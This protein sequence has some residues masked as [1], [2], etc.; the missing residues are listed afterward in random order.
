M[1]LDTGLIRIESQPQLIIRLFHRMQAVTA[2]TCHCAMGETFTFDQALIFPTSD[3]NCAIIPKHVVVNQ[4]RVSVFMEDHL[5]IFDEVIARLVIQ[6]I[7]KIRVR[8]IGFEEAVTL[9]ANLGLLMFIESKRVN[10]R[11]I[12]F[13]GKL[14]IGVGR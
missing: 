1:A 7:F 10:D 3:T 11:S 6:S 5:T 12:G 9:S 2:Q 14:Y 4:A 13:S 8:V